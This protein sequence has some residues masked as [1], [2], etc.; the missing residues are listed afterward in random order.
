MTGWASRAGYAAPFLSAGRTF[1]RQIIVI[2]ALVLTSLAAF[3]AVAMMGGWA[4]VPP[5]Y[6]AAAVAAVTRPREA[7]I[8]LLV[9]M[10]AL[11]PQTVDTTA[12]LSAVVYRMPPG[13][14]GHMPF[15][16]SPLELLLVLTTLAAYFPRA[17]LP[18]RN[19]ANV[20]IVVF[21]V[22]L[23]LIAGM[24]YG[25]R[26]GA[27]DNLIYT[28]ARGIIFSIFAF[29]LAL[30]LGPGNWGTLAKWTMIAAAILAAFTL[31]R[32]FVYVRPGEL[33]TAIEFAFAHESPIFLATGLM[34]AGVLALREG[35][36]AEQ[37]MG[38]FLYAALMLAAMI[39]TQ[40]RAA[41]AVL[42]VGVLW[43]GLAY[44]PRRP[45][46]VVALGV[47]LLLLGSV[48]T[49]VYW[50]EEYG[51]TAQPARAIR[52]QIDPSPR[53]E[54]S[55]VYRD[56]ER[57]NV[58]ETLRVSPIFGV[59]FGREFFQFEPLPDLRDYWPLQYHTPHQNVL[60]LW[61]KM[62]FAGIVVF[63]SVAGI[64]ISRC[65]QTMRSRGSHDTAYLA[66]VVIAAVLLMSLIYATIDLAFT[67]VR[68][69]ALLA[70]VTGL[71]FLLYTTSRDEDE[72]RDEGQERRDRLK[73][74]WTRGG[75]GSTR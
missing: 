72:Y 60:W 54:S 61:L 2:G 19:P 13:I 1:A 12:Y 62:G 32:Y 50:N 33:E 17:D 26:H 23:V 40:R 44:F 14:D 59:G 21:L 31:Y 6:L 39:V 42:L 4:L 25:F 47:P 10:I 18:K 43:V 56:T 8:G 52:S 30:R 65:L 41:T 24:L 11:E 55:D 58:M 20:P 64:A 63:L 34:I 15:T 74:Q 66:G 53:D 49:A 67:G 45:V 27:P 57:A 70:G 29:L 7:A 69:L 36:T 5:L 3:M 46:L 16:V 37:R 35:Q 38:F 22:P 28:E 68:P 51:A 48:Y 75:K 73:G 9:V 71:A